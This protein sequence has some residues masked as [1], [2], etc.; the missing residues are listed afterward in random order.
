MLRLREVQQMT[1]RSRSSIYQDIGLG[2]FPKQ[3][4]IGVRAVAFSEQ[5][6]FDW[7]HRRIAERDSA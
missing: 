6:V 1:G 4:K 2:R 5:E 7:L 3:I